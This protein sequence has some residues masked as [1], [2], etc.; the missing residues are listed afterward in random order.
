MKWAVEWPEPQTLEERLA[1]ARRCDEDLGW[2]PHVEVLVDDLDD[3]LCVA[4]GA[5]PAGGYVF[6]HGGQLLLACAPA[7]GEIFFQE[8]ELFAFLR[9]LRG[10]VEK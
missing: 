7:R 10:R 5:W 3:E 9:A 8:E 1:C 2:S 4:L 6:A